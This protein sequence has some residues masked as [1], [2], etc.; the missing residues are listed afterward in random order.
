MT[1]PIRVL[2]IGDELVAGLGDARALGWTGRVMART[3]N[4]PPILAMTLAVPGED[5]AHLATRWEEEVGGGSI[6][7]HSA[8]WSSASARTISTPVKPLPGHG[9]IWPTSL[10]RPSACISSP[11][12]S[13]TTSARFSGEDPGR[14]HAGLPG[15]LRTSQHG[16]C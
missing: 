10:I 12:S 16:L 7:R 5:S 2:F 6:P 11:S 9:F 13:A 4:D 15:C 1:N 8:D 14:S 3:A